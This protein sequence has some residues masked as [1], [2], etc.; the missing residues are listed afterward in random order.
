MMSAPARR[1][2]VSASTVFDQC[3]QLANAIRPLWAYLLALA[4]EAL[5]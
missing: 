5:G 4:G 1:M 3:E 2:P